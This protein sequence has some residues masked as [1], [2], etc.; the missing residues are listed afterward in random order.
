MQEPFLP[1]QGGQGARGAPGGIGAV[2]AAV[3]GRHADH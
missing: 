1:C 3:S 2:G